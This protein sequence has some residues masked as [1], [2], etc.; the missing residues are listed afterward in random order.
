M[1]VR[2]ITHCPLSL[3]ISTHHAEH[4]QRPTALSCP[5]FVLQSAI[6]LGSTFLRESPISKP[7]VGYLYFSV[8]V[9]QVQLEPAAA[10]V[11]MSTV[12]AKTTEPITIRLIMVSPPLSEDLDRD[13]YRAD[14]SNA[15]RESVEADCNDV[16]LSSVVDSLPARSH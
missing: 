5:V 7:P 2:G 13:D 12:V 15:I 16:L 3:Q 8:V 4:G 14:R 6:Y 1:G 11:G 9:V 10:T